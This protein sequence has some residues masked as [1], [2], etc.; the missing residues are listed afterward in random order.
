MIIAA[1]EIELMLSELEN[2]II[3]DNL[4]FT[5]P[6]S[7]SYLTAKLEL[8]SSD[9]DLRYCYNVLANALNKP[10]ATRH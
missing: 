4:D 2:S 9:P 5:D 1:P 8:E 7:Q 3:A 6:L 10:L